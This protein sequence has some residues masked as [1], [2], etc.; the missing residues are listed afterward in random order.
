MRN[1]VQASTLE[2]NQPSHAELLKGIDHE[3]RAPLS[4]MTFFN[5]ELIRTTPAQDSPID[6]IN[7]RFNLG[8]TIKLLGKYQISIG[9]FLT[10]RPPELAEAVFTFRLQE[11]NQPDIIRLRATDHIGSPKKNQVAAYYL[12][13][14]AEAFPD[15]TNYEGQPL[16]TLVGELAD[17]AISGITQNTLLAIISRITNYQRLL[18]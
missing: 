6:D 9:R 14:Q 1:N 3:C 7:R 16:R 5:P 11:P 10:T 15:P 8:E 12:V 18:R 2:N 13:W 4:L 17:L